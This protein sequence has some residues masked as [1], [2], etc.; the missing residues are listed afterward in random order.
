[1]VTDTGT[2]HELNE[3]AYAE[4]R[5]SCEEAAKALGHALLGEASVDEVRDSD[6]P[7]PIRSRALHVVEEIARVLEFVASIERGAL[8]NAGRM[9]FESHASLRDLFEVSCP[10][11]DLLVDLAAGR[12][13]DGVLGARMTG[14]GFG[15]CVVTLCRPD[16]ACDLQE[17]YEREFLKAF[18][19]PPRS[20]MTTASAGAHAE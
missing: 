11:L 12:G 1:M 10:E 8:E 14:G 4:R 13:Q 6:L 18:G 3:G 15:G 19:R 16:R 9:M 5:R 20:F 7:E 2:R 17:L